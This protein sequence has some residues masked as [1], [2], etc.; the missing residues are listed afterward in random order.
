LADRTTKIDESGRQESRKEN[1]IRKAGKEEGTE[2]YHGFLASRFG[3]CFACFP[4]FLI[5]PESVRICEICG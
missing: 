1:W 3:F 5:H 4:I 2:Q